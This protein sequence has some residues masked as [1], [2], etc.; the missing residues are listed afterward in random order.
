MTRTIL[1]INLLVVVYVI[2]LSDGI[3]RYKFVRNPIT[4]KVVIG[5]KFDWSKFRPRVVTGYG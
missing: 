2:R 3:E 5:Y 4:F 1:Y